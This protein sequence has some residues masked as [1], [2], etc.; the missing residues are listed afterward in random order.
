MAGFRVQFHRLGV[1][2]EIGDHDQSLESVL[3]VVQ[4][5]FSLD[6]KI[7]NFCPVIE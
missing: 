7:A 6:Q 4:S 3:G 2:I 1:E 5:V